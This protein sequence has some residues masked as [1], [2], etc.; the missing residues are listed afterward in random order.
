MER[1]DED[2]VVCCA[3]RSNRRCAFSYVQILAP[4]IDRHPVIEGLRTSVHQP[5][6]R[7]PRAVYGAIN[8]AGRR[9]ANFQISPVSADQRQFIDQIGL[10]V[11][12]ATPH[13]PDTFPN[14][15]IVME[16]PAGVL[17]AAMSVQYAHTKSPTPS[18]TSTMP[19]RSRAVVG[20]LKMKCVTPCANKTSTSASVRTLAA[21]AMAKARNQNC[22]AKAPMKP[23][24]SEGFQALAMARKTAGSRGA[25]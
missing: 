18:T 7:V 8:I 11:R 10:A 5:V 17:R 25:R 23:A 1:F 4:Q 22:E 21:V 14:R 6:A 19:A 2:S 12:H 24:N 16:F 15:R 13:A 3:A 9:R 20:C